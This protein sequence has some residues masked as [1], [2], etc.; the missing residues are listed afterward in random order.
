MSVA[1]L[2]LPRP[3]KAAIYFYIWAIEDIAVC[4]CA[5]CDGSSVTPCFTKFNEA[6]AGDEHL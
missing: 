6:K 2:F 4:G 5:G 3:L 1:K